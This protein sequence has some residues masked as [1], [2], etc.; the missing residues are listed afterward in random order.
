MCLV[1]TNVK[2][3]HK[4]DQSGRMVF[5]ASREIRPGEECCIAYFDLTQYKDLDSRRDHL[6]RSFR[7]CCRCEKCLA[8]E[9]AEQVVEWTGMPLVD[10]Y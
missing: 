2:V 9:P 10:E 1:L 7:F 3:S 8:E 6:R 5:T 4:P